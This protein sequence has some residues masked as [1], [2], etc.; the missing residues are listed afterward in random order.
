MER[1]YVTLATSAI[2]A[3]IVLGR[4]AP[5]DGGTTLLSNGHTY[6]QYRRDLCPACNAE[7][8]LA[9]KLDTE[10]NEHPEGCECLRDPL[11][12]CRGF[13][14]EGE[15]RGIDALDMRT[16]DM[17]AQEDMRQE[18]M[19]KAIARLVNAG[20]MTE[21]EALLWVESGLAGLRSI[22]AQ[23][24]A[25]LA[26]IG[27]RRSEAEEK[28]AMLRT[29]CQSAEWGDCAEYELDRADSSMQWWEDLYDNQARAYRHEMDAQ[30][31]GYALSRYH[32]RN[33]RT[34][35]ANTYELMVGGE[36][37]AA[38]DW[39]DAQSR[40]LDICGADPKDVN[41]K[42]RG[43]AEFGQGGWALRRGTSAQKALIQLGSGADFV[44]EE[45]DHGYSYESARQ[46]AEEWVPRESELPGGDL[47]GRLLGL[48]AK[49]AVAAAERRNKTYLR[50]AHFLRKC[51]MLE[52]KA[53][54]RFEWAV[55][56]E[57]REK[58]FALVRGAQARVW[59]TM[60]R[61]NKES[62][63]WEGGSHGAGDA[64]TEWYLTSAQIRSLWS[65][66]DRRQ[67]K[68]PAQSEEQDS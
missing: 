18:R 63:S 43:E 60:G 29:E 65:L 53:V 25:H 55:A 26:A 1:Q 28:A 51:R 45:R 49:R 10:P 39:L 24:R 38:M 36:D 47:Q 6:T 16:A 61:W 7:L 56:K 3:D 58:S 44:S 13:D 2:M 27:K 30:R 48:A 35:M 67:D 21:R 42:F 11:T 54:S 68:A 52:R 41:G 14:S 37:S 46:D 40:E 34:I 32:A 12:G 50:L 22:E 19:V 57:W 15:V 5:Q 20:E 9:D 64:M 59:A 62:Q 4:T 17:R 8:E 66:N 31:R 23:Q 33:D